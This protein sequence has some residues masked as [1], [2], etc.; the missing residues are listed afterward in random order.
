MTTVSEA[1][2]FD[3]FLP[4][5]NYVLDITQNGKD[6]GWKI[7]LGGPEHPKAVAFADKQVRRNMEEGKRVRMAL[8]SGADLPDDEKEPDAV[9]RENIG[10]IVARIVDWTPIKVGGKVYAFSDD[11]AAEL[12]VRPAFGFALTQI[13]RA[14]DAEGRFTKR[15]A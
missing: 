8:A 10:W 6:T 2:E 11:A 5:E 15:S 14:L 13:K 9:R 1:I 4:T 3:A 12:L 7:T